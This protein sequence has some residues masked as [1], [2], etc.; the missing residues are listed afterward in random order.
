MGLLSRLLGTP[1]GPAALVADL[2]DAYAAELGLAHALR[3]DAERA[4]YPHLAARLAQLAAVEERHA[5]WLADELRRLGAEP[6]T[7]PAEPSTGDSPWERACDARRRAQ[8]KRRRL[9][10]LVT[11]RPPDEDAVADVLRR[12][13][14]E[15]AAGLA[16]LE[17]VVVR[18]DPHARD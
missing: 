13:E 7:V 16:V 6:P 9:V 14:R 11:R 8:R 5:A 18:S 10:E 4:R 2:R 12:I 1:G 15:D 17:G 3:A